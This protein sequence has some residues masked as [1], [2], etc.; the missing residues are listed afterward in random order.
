MLFWVVQIWG[1]FR[2]WRGAVRVAWL[3]ALAGIALAGCGLTEFGAHGTSNEAGGSGNGASLG[4][5]GLGGRA[6]DTSVG[7]G[8]SADG[9]VAGLLDTPWDERSQRVELRC[10]GFFEGTMR[11]RA[12]R[13]QLSAEQLQLLEGLRFGPPGATCLADGMSCDVAITS[14]RG[15]VTHF[16]TVQGDSPC[17][18]LEPG[19]AYASFQPL[20]DQIDCKFSLQSKNP[21]FPSEG[22]LQGFSATG[23]VRQQLMLADAKRSYHVELEQCSS[24]MR[25]DQYTLELYGADPSVPLAVG[26]PIADPDMR[27]ACLAFDVE[28]ET[29]TLAELV[30]TTPSGYDFYLS[31]R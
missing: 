10:F 29:A 31:F 3:A 21:L 9:G 28:V 1:L 4:G 25:P 30:I 18:R 6:G 14:D 17:N 24:R 12:D 8:G 19:L 26:K 23:T 2:G 5:A 27:G 22:C 16:D 11:F 15:E 20:L 7:M 13:A